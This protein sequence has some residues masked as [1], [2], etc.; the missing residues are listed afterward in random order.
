MPPSRRPSRTAV[1]VSLLGEL[2]VDYATLRESQTREA[3]ADQNVEAAQ[4]SLMIA[5]ERFQHGLGS[6]LDMAEAK[7]QVDN[8][9]SQV[10]L[11]Q[12][13]EAQSIH[14]IAVLLG[15]TADKV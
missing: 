3:I 8:V 15:D 2:G 14:A 11:L 4:E 1:L 12:T 6:E 10:P 5:Q 9:R 13:A 7:A